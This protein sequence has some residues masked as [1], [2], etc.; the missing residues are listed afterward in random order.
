MKALLAMG[1]LLLAA[2]AHGA[3]CEPEL[4]QGISRDLHGAREWD[5]DVSNCK[6]LPHRDRQAVLVLAYATHG[7]HE[8][9]YDVDLVLA[10]TSSGKVIARL[11]REAL[12]TSDAFGLRSTGV[13]TANYAIRPGVRAFGIVEQWG[14]SSR[15]AHYDVDVLSLY[16]VSGSALKPVLEGL[17]VD[18]FQGEEDPY[19]LV[20]RYVVIDKEQPSGYRELQINQRVY[21]Q[22]CSTGECTKTRISSDAFRLNAVD[23]V[24]DVPKRLG[25]FGEN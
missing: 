4:L 8:I 7:E 13:D 2:A 12:W 11:Y 24:Y 16:T 15:I 20:K 14:T 21:E 22:D 6:H 18:V 5:R 3:E 19:T 23:G 9:T 1:L 17:V 10:D 25:L